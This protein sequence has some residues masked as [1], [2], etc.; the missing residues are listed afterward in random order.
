M[1]CTQH[2]VCETSETISKQ[3]K[4]AQI[5]IALRYHHVVEAFLYVSTKL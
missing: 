4:S 3:R 2:W 5:L 1:L